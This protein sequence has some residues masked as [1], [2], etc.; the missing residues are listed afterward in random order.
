MDNEMY[1]LDYE[2][3]NNKSNFLYLPNT[4]LKYFSN[5]EKLLIKSYKLKKND[6]NYYSL[7]TIKKIIKHFIYLQNLCKEPLNI[8]TLS[9][10]NKLNLK[11]IYNIFQL[12]LNILSKKLSIF[13]NKFNDEL[14][15][16]LTHKFKYK[17]VIK[18]E[19]VNLGIYCKLDL[20]FYNNYYK[21]DYI[22]YNEK[23]SEMVLYKEKLKDKEN[24]YKKDELES[25]KIKENQMMYMNDPYILK[26]KENVIEYFYYVEV[27]FLEEIFYNTSMNS[28]CCKTE[29]YYYISNIMEQML[30]EY[31]EIENC[32]FKQELNHSV[33]LFKLRY[34]NNE[35]F[36][37]KKINYKDI[38]QRNKKLN[39]EF[40][41]VYK[42]ISK[43]IGFNLFSN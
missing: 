21:Y 16:I 39:Q 29:K 1:Q 28:K 8:E 3:K 10:I 37:N 35:H 24:K 15:L 20:K 23:I 25:Q 2:F 17:N 13:D 9:K 30:N 26:L 6:N 34:K 31:G 12:N 5:I 41:R 33:K 11:S 38:K 40:K 14:K 27:E 36:K 32:I 7:N 42:L 22:S 19:F 4:D 43:N 18:L